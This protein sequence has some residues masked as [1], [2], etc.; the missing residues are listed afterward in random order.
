MEKFAI[1]LVVGGLVGAL[2]VSNNQKMRTLVK[3]AQDEAQ[4][5]IDA[6]MDDKISK[7]EK[8]AEQAAEK[9]D[10]LVQDVKEKFTR[11]SKKN[12]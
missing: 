7:M 11:K 5:K 4:E 6:F 12:A 10:E 9:A 2:L 8:G 1:G 3:K